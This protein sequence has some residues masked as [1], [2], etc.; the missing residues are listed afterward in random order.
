MSSSAPLNPLN[1][2]PIVLAG[3]RG[4][5]MGN[6]DLPKVLTPLYEKPLIQHL[7]EALKGSGLPTPTIVVGFRSD[8]VQEA[9]GDTYTYALQAEQRGTGDAVASCPESVRSSAEHFLIANGD[10]PLFQPETLRS[11]AETHIASGATLT[12]ATVTSTAE[13]FDM[14]GRIIRDADNNVVAIR[15]ARDCSPEETAITEKNPALYVISGSFLWDALARL[16]PENAQGE[17]YLT[18]V[19][20]DAITQGLPVSTVPLTHWWE[21]LGVNNLADLAVAAQFAR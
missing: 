2:Q 5:R 16:T 10:H 17:Y 13:A 8:L 20:A 7:L 12:M 4:K 21:G 15:E 11:L 3:G 9:L 18:D 19:I 1:V 14:F 6:P